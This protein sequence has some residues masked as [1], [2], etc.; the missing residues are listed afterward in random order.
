MATELTRPE[1]ENVSIDDLP[2]WEG[3]FHETDAR[4][5]LT[6]ARFSRCTG[7]GVEVVEELRGMAGH[8]DGCSQEA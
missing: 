4:G 3:P 7:C 1:T 6:G 2:A 5:R 8:R